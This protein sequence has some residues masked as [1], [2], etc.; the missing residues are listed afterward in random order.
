M[1]DSQTDRKKE[2]EKLVRQKIENSAHRARFGTDLPPEKED[3][4]P[5]PSSQR[6]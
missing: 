3:E 6:N 5:R 4:E 1:L 2:E